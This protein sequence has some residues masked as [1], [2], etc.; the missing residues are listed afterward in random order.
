MVKM[1]NRLHEELKT[2]VPGLSP[3]D[4]L[5]EA[6]PLK[7]GKETYDLARLQIWN[8]R[9]QGFDGLPKRIDSLNEFL[10]ENRQAYVCCNPDYYDK[11][12][13]LPR[14]DWQRLFESVR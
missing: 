11:L 9:K 12:K 4:L 6:S 7:E 8:E 10:K 13:A 2:F 3:T 5:I 14:S 1:S